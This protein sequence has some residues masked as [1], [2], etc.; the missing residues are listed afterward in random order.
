[1]NTVMI[2]ISLY[3]VK[4]LAS[5]KDGFTNIAVPVETPSESKEEEF[6]L[7]V[8]YTGISKNK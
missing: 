2:Y 3:T 8:N 7:Y 5:Q 4:A 6:K 1:M